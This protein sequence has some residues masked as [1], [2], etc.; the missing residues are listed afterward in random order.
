MKKFLTL[1]S[2]LMSLSLMAAAQS[3]ESAR[4]RSGESVKKA[5]ALDARKQ[6]SQAVDTKGVKAEMSRSEMS[7]EK[8][9]ASITS[10]EKEMVELEGTPGFSRE[11]YDQRLAAL[12][13]KRDHLRSDN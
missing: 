11:A 10:L 5:D 3:S 6:H 1:F 12:R 13:A 8:L 9:E 2:V 4:T 7:L